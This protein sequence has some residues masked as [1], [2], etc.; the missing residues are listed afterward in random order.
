MKK[1]NNVTLKPSQD[2]IAAFVQTK[3]IPPKTGFDIT[4]ATIWITSCED[5]FYRNLIKDLF[6]IARKIIICTHD[7]TRP[8][9]EVNHIVSALAT[10]FLDNQFFLFLLLQDV[11]KK[12]VFLS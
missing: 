4:W 2:S 12:C 5:S 8:R 9:N 7:S 3:E 11:R 10:I 1:K 6:R